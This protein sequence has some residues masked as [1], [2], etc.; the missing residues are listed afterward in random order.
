MNNFFTSCTRLVTV[1]ASLLF[2]GAALASMVPA[3]GAQESENASRLSTLVVVNDGADVSACAQAIS[4]S[5]ASLDY[6]GETIGVIV[7]QATAAQSTA[8][9]ALA[10]VESLELDNGPMT[11]GGIA[12]AMN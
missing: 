5:G 10:C 3:N 1:A 6:V 7:V 11:G 8:I 12:G 2:A 4:N 9:Q